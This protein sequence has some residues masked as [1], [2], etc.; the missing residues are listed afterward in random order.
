MGVSSGPARR[1]SLTGSVRVSGYRDRRRG[2]KV[3][4]RFGLGWFVAK[5]S[6]VS[7]SSFAIWRTFVPLERSIT[8]SEDDFSHPHMLRGTH[9]LW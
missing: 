7:T 3:A 2:S 6:S 8:S 4:R 1:E 9:E 5:R